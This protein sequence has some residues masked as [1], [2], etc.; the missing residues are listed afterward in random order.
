[1]NV[2]SK[3]DVIVY[4]G[5]YP[6][7]PWVVRT[8]K[9]R[10]LSVFRDDSVHGF[11]PTGRVVICE[12]ADGGKTWSAGRV[13]IDHGGVDDRNAAIGEM[14]DG[15]LLVC[16]NTYTA[17]QSSKSRVIRSTDGGQSWE[18]DVAIDER[19]ARTRSAP[20]ALTTGDILIPYYVAPGNGSLAAISGDGGRTW[21]TVSVPDVAGFIGDEWDV[22]EVEPK[23]LIGLIRNS[24]PSCDGHFWMTESRDAGRTWAKPLL[25][26][27]QSK[28]APSPPH[29]GTHGGR[30]V[31]TYADQRMVSVS[32]VRPVDDRFVKW[33]V[34]NRLPCYQ[35]QPD[36][37]PIADASYPA[38]VELS[39]DRRFVVDYEIRPG[40][41][42]IAGYFVDIPAG[43]TGGG[44][45]V[46]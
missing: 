46:R 36:G 43:W 35:Y 7:W 30:P 12:S 42:Q 40:S 9:G 44:K 11:S 25:T 31:L 18:D 32:M 4:R 39:A 8:R 23:R 27:V 38:S 33:D 6:G 13:V 29:L 22:L 24:H 14:P 3:P 41:H 19:D 26:N 15:T 5:S 21:T 45:M 28:R 20:I 1:M 17:K 37:K 34:A 10:L 16:Y 2:K